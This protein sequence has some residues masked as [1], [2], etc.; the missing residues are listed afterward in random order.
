M[1]RLKAHALC[2]ATLAYV[3]MEQVTIGTKQGGPYGAR[4]LDCELLVGLL[5][6]RHKWPPDPQDMYVYENTLGMVQ[7]GA[8]S[9]AG[10]GDGRQYGPRFGYNDTVGEL[11]QE[12]A[13][14][15]HAWLE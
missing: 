3:F 8:A 14:C 12:S 4:A 10:G 11:C 1:R 7:L 15:G 6:D 9:D 13:A 2:D 5:L